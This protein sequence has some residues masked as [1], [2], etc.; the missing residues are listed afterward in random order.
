MDALE[1]ARL[2]HGF[3]LWAF[4]IMPE[5]VHLLVYPGHEPQR[6]ADFLYTMKKSVSQRALG[7]V[8]RHAPHF[9]TRMRDL[10]PNGRV[11]H[12]FWQ[13]GPGYDENLFSPAKIWQKIDYIHENP[14][15]RRL[16]SHPADWGWSSFRAYENGA[17]EPIRID[18]DSLPDDRR[19]RD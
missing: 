16:C 2:T 5:H 14:V 6:M 18:F 19:R 12:R 3:D 7:F 8:R 13:R 9:L 4:V 1:R 15:R 17:A 11:T 10:Q